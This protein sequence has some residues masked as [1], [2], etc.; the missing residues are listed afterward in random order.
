M[1]PLVTNDLSNDFDT[2]KG[3]IIDNFVKIQQGVTEIENDSGSDDLDG[4]LADVQKEMN[5][6]IKRITLGTD[7]D[8]IR[9]VVTAILQEQEVIK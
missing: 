5:D 8:T 2:A 7:E 1:K 9:T 4:K 6:K 3:Q